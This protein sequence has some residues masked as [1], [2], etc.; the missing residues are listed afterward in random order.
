MS[1]E[2]MQYFW[3]RRDFSPKEM[4][5]RG[6]LRFGHVKI[7]LGTKQIHFLNCPHSHT[8]THTHTHT[9]SHVYIHTYIYIYM[10]LLHVHHVMTFMRWWCGDGL[11]KKWDTGEWSRVFLIHEWISAYFQTT[12]VKTCSSDHE[13]VSLEYLYGESHELLTWLICLQK[14]PLV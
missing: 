7:L 4:K 14:I 6:S 5:R 8:H 2:T 12:S 9:H 10:L 13:S 1:H 3:A 11:S